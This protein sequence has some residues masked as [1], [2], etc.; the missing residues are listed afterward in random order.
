M[1]DGN[2]WCYV[3]DFMV[4]QVVF[5]IGLGFGMGW[6]M[7]FEMVFCGVWMVLFV[8]CE[9]FLEEIVEMICVV[10]GEVFV[11]FGD[12]CDEDS[13][14]IVMGCIKDYYGQF[15]VLVNNVGG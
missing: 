2:L 8:W 10:G 13:I 14:E 3:L 4:G 15:D 11:V 1:S 12:I 7:V 6:V 9:E 5:V